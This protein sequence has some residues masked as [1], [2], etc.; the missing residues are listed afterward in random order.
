MLNSP[1]KP[2]LLHKSNNV[3]NGDYLHQL[4]W[5]GFRSLLH[6]DN[7]QVKL[8]TRNQNECTLQFPEMKNIELNVQ[9]AIL[10]GE[11]IVLDE[12]NK[13]CFESVMSRFQASNELSIKRGTKT[14]PT[15][16]VAYDILFL[17]DQDIT[18]LAL[19]DRLKHL[20]NVVHFSKEISACESFEDGEELFHSVSKMGLEGIVSKRKGSKYTLDT[21]SHDWVK[22]K[23]YQFEEVEIAAIRKDQFAWSL[24]KNGKYVGV[25]EFVPPD[26]KK[27]FNQISKQIIRNED[28]NWIYLEPLIKCKVKF[29]CWT[30]S[31]LMRSPSF[32]EFVLDA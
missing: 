17:N 2:M 19:E 7:G 21:R 9:N 16:F 32:V 22:V 11:M 24:T 3:P 26:E 20:Y 23:N 25:T 12:S 18:K 15:H 10:D 28:K 5:D 27:A 4:K 14:L 29:Q 1:I 8:F 30:K 6:Y 31:G 13:P